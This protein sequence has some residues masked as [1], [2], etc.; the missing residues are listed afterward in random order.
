MSSF[1]QIVKGA[2][3]GVGR[4]CSVILHRSLGTPC[5]VL[6]NTSEKIMPLLYKHQY[7]HSERYMKDQ[8]KKTGIN[9][10]NFPDIPNIYNCCIFHSVMKLNIEYLPNNRSDNG[11][12]K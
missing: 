2:F 1:L 9:A 11:G 6:R 8:I 10:R 3:T 12:L 5:G 4:L 7:Q